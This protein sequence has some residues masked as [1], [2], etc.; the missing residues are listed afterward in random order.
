MESIVIKVV[1][2]DLL[3]VFLVYKIKSEVLIKNIALISMKKK[4]DARVPEAH[5][6]STTKGGY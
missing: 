3:C 6:S 2:N 4:N 5:T 1:S